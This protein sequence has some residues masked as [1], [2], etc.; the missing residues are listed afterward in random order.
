MS[1]NERLSEGYVQAVELKEGWYYVT[2]L[3][4]RKESETTLN[5]CENDCQRYSSCDHAAKLLDI[6]MILNGE[7]EGV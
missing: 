3:C 5:A 7:K 2:A 6:E 1:I 4:S